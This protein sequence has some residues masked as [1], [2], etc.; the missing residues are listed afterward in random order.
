LRRTRKCVADDMTGPDYRTAAEYFRDK[1]HAEKR[2]RLDGTSAAKT[3]TERARALRARRDA[4]GLREVRG[5]WAPDALHD[6]VRAAAAK[7]ARR[8]A[9]IDRAK[10]P[11]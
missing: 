9:R 10:E 11:T 2:E 5:I 3:S 4:E 6:E 1:A 8:R 7:I